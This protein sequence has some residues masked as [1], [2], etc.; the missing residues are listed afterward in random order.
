MTGILGYKDEVLI[1]YSLKKTNAKIFDVIIPS[2]QWEHDLFFFEAIGRVSQGDLQSIWF[3]L[4]NDGSTDS[5]TEIPQWEYG[6]V[7]ESYR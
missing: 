5:T 6:K 3:W 2:V 1:G 7:S 4:I